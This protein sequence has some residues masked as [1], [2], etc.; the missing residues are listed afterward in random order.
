MFRF[1]G[2]MI[3]HLTFMMLHLVGLLVFGIGLF[4]T[5]PMHLLYM[6]KG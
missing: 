1:I 3:A 2:K 5:I 6:K 4:F